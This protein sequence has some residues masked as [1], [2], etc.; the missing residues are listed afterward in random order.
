MAVYVDQ[1]RA[2]P[3]S[4]VS[5]VSLHWCH[6]LA[7]SLDELHD[8]AQRI[9]LK[10]EWFQERPLLYHCHYDLT[11]Q[12]RAAAIAAGAQEVNTREFMRLLQRQGKHL[13]RI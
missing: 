10:R 8:M 5:H 4:R 3:Q 2:Y 11:P 1:L 6:M 13:R 9:G 7:D 12:S